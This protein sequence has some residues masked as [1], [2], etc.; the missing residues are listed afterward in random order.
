MLVDRQRRPVGRQHLGLQGLDL[1][2]DGAHRRLGTWRGRRSGERP[3]ERHQ[4]ALRLGQPQVEVAGVGLGAVPVVETGP[5]VLAD[6]R[7]RRLGQR[8]YPGGHAGQRRGRRRPEVAGQHV[9]HPLPFGVERGHV[10]AL[11]GGALVDVDGGAQVGPSGGEAVQRQQAPAV[12]QIL[13]GLGQQ[14]LVA[15]L[16]LAPDRIRVRSA[17]HDR[18]PARQLGGERVGRGV[19]RRGHR[20]PEQEEEEERPGLGAGS[21]SGLGSGVGGHVACIR[22]CGATVLPGCRSG[23][24]D[25]V[26]LIGHGAP[27]NR[28]PRPPRPRRHPRRRRADRSVGPPHA[29][30]HLPFARLARR[31]PTLFQVR[32]PP[33]RRR[34]QVPR[35]DQRRLLAVR[36]RSRP[37]GAHPL[38]RQPR[39]RPRPGRRQPGDP[40]LGGDARGGAGGQARRGGRLR[41]R[42]RLLRGD[43]GGP[44]GDRRPGGRRDRGHLHPPLRRPAGD[45]RPGDGGPRAAG[46]GAGPRLGGGAGGGRRSGER[47]RPRRDFAVAADPGGGGR[48]GGGRRRLPVLHHRRPAAVRT[49]ADRRRRPAD[50]PLGAHLPGPSRAA[51][52]RRHGGGGGHCGGDAD[53]VG[54]DEAGDRA[55]GGGGGGRRSSLAPILLRSR[56]RPASGRE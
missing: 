55:L 53:G 14:R 36:R 52:R 22:R 9:P 46:R 50:G 6:L 42:D 38:L 30:P 41:R 34:F 51:D 27:C 37:R 2:V 40:L 35:R 54:A 4:I 23:S 1:G 45:R 31:R 18:G 43:G 33:A 49:G 44:R 16:D 29:G 13:R 8:P 10:V 56:S 19:R 21:E 25:V 5:I 7:Q 32:E 48:A 47:H 28:A 39:R 15:L 17:L 20:G 24:A 26:E 12:A 3:Q 11:L